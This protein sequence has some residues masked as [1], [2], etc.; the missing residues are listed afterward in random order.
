[1]GEPRLGGVRQD[2]AGAEGVGCGDEAQGTEPVGRRG[3]AV[4][5]SGEESF[6]LRDVGVWRGFDAHGQVGQGAV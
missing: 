4:F 2:E 6:V 5:K 1:M 3:S